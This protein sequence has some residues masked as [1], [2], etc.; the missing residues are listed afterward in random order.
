MS[1]IT[2]EVT[3]VT[4]V[5]ADMQTILHTK[6]VDMFVVCLYT[7]FHVHSSSSLL[8]IA[9]GLKAEYLISCGHHV[10]VLHCTQ[11]VPYIHIFSEDFFDQAPCHGGVLREWRY[12]TTHY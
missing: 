3:S 10:F 9:V 6:Y 12:S 5:I 1:D 4:F 8:V 11:K 7:K 2:S